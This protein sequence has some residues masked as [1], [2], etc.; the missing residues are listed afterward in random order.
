[1][2]FYAENL[3]NL[4]FNHIYWFGTW[5]NCELGAFILRNIAVI[6]HTVH[7]KLHSLRGVV[8][9]TQMTEEYVFPTALVVFC[10]ETCRYVVGKVTALAEY[11]L[12]E[13]QRIRALEQHLLI[14]V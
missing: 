5:Q 4:Q 12:L 1:M 8:L 6:I 9:I 10:K 14:V 13:E 2:Y 7:H 3:H 11:A